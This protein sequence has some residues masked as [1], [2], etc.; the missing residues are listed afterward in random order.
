MPNGKGSDGGNVTRFPPSGASPR[1]KALEPFDVFSPGEWYGKP[2][3]EYD[4]MV[5]GC[6]LRGTVG[7]LSGDG[8]IGKSLIMQQ[9]L[10]AASIGKNWLGLAT[11]KCKG[12]GFFCEDDKEELHRRQERINAHYECDHPDVDALYVSRVGMENVLAEFDRRTDRLLSTPLWDQ[13]QSAVLEFGS[14][15]IVI[16]TIADAYGGNEI[17]R[18]QVRRF[19][20]ELRRLAVRIQGVIIITA[21]PSLVGMSSGTGLSGSTAWHNSVRSRMYLTKPRKTNDDTKEGEDDEDMNERV[22]KTMKNNQGPG[23]GILPLRWEAGVFVRNDATRTGF[24]GKIELDSIV[25]SAIA[26]LIERGTKIGRDPFAK[27]SIWSFS[28]QITSLRS[29]RRTDLENSVERLISAGRLVVVDIGPPS[30]THKFVRPPAL[31]YPGES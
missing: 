15:F 21:H 2:A 26:N 30:R 20:T 17:V 31:R 28:R 23:Q 1:P 12:F 27:N 19:I 4:W 14:Q 29:H 18:N 16:D 22:L 25:W 5:D 11:Q 8:G 6:L 7:M 10:T 9:L 3:P 13:F 24:L